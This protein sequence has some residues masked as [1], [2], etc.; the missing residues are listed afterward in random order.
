MCFIVPQQTPHML[1]LT[2]G[3]HLV[4]AARS[5]LAT[6]LVVRTPVQEERGCASTGVDTTPSH[7]LYEVI[8]VLVATKHGDFVA[9][10][11]SRTQIQTK[12]LLRGPLRCEKV[13]AKYSRPASWYALHSRKSAAARARS[14]VPLRR[15]DSMGSSQCLQQRS[16]VVL[17]LANFLEYQSK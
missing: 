13:C 4:V 5:V 14:S 2:C 11:P 16:M 6:G 10:E 9:Y 7:G 12:K 3:R 15:T 17:S 8:P 1:Q